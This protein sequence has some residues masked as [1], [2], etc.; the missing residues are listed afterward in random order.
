M[1]AAL[2][3]ALRQVEALRESVCWSL[4]GDALPAGQPEAMYSWLQSQGF[5]NAIRL[6][7]DSHWKHQ[8]L[9]TTVDGA[10]EDKFGRSIQSLAPRWFSPGP[11]L[12]DIGASRSGAG[13][14]QSANFVTTSAF[15]RLL[16][17]SEQFEMDVLKALF[18]YRPSGVQTNGPK[19]PLVEVED[20]V[21][22]EVPRLEGDKQIYEKPA[23]WT[24]IRRHAENNVE[25]DK[26]CASVF[27]FRT[28]AP[29]FKPKVKQEWY[30]MRNA[31]AHGRK[32]VEMSL[33]EYVDAEVFVIKS[34]FHVA[35]ECQEKH[36]LI[37]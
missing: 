20:A 5:G 32:G 28:V 26:I 33:M 7:D 29:E 14:S 10:F 9:S 1:R 3:V 31:I 25:R 6:T 21:I 37:I 2:Y 34:M 23:I 11:G 36:Y 35:Q 8:M 12:A 19:L 15:V 22:L 27:G 4:S 30:E 17:C 18:Q 13:W 24:W 16:G